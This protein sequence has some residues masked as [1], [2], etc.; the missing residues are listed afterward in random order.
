MRGVEI[1]VHRL[2]I[3]IFMFTGHRLSLYKFV[4]V[5]VTSSVLFSL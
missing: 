4:V 5:V 2:F 1:E 3:L